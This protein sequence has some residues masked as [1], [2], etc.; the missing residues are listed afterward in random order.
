MARLIKKVCPNCGDKSTGYS[1]INCG[2]SLSNA[3]TIEVET[4]SKLSFCPSC[5]EQIKKGIR[6]CPECGEFISKAIKSSN[7]YSSNTYRTQS[8]GG[9]DT[10]MLVISALIPLVG[11]I[12]GAICLSSD[13]EYKKQDGKTYIIIAIIST[14]ISTLVLVKFGIV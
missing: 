8:S 13:D 14:I 2:E 9:S 1:C 10:I 4:E 3:R 7:R 6:N 5:K 11:Y 12:T